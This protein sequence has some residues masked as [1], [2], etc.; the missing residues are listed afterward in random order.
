ML[1]DL[2]NVLNSADVPN[3]YKLEDMQDIADVGRPECLR[4]NLQ[5]TEMNIMN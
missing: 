4:R 2:N 3:I 1:E 5:P